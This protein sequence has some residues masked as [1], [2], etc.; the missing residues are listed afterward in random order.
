MTS[1]VQDD[2]ATSISV[3]CD[4]V[5]THVFMDDSTDD[6]RVV[7][8]TVIPDDFLGIRWL[9][10]GM[11]EPLLAEIDKRK[12]YPRVRKKMIAYVH[13]LRQ[14]KAGTAKLPLAPP[15]VLR[16]LGITGHV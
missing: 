14:L 5:K 1:G 3:S 13:L 7:E 11:V 16:Q 4:G 8:D 6:G 15:H 2:V 10:S 9:K 12:D